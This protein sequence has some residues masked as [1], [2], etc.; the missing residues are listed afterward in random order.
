M[1]AIDRQ[2]ITFGSF[3]DDSVGFYEGLAAFGVRFDNCCNFRFSV[4]TG[5]IRPKNKEYFIS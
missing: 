1:L 4:D 2:L 5:P 3:C